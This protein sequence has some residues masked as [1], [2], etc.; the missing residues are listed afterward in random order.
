MLNAIQQGVRELSERGTSHNK[1]LFR[2][3]EPILKALLLY[4][5]PKKVLQRLLLSP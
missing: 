5:M 1:G 4:L 2:F 3:L